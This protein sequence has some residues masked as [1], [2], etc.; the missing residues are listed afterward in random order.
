MRGLK[1]PGCFLLLASLFLICVLPG[2]AQSAQLRRDAS[3]RLILPQPQRPA[4]DQQAI[5]VGP[6]YRGAQSM[7]GDEAWVAQEMYK[8]RQDMM[9]DAVNRVRSGGRDDSRWL[10]R[11]VGPFVVFLVITGFVLWFIRAIL[12]N[13]RW[14]KMARIQTDAHTKVLDRLGSSQELLGYVESEAGKRFL[15]ATPFQIDRGPSPVFPFSRILWSAQAGVVITLVGVGFLALTTQLTEDT[16][17]LLVFGYLALALG[18]GFLLSAGL[19]YILSKRLGLLDSAK[20]GPGE[21]L[22]QRPQ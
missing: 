18:I 17:A 6:E 16:R 9:R 21:A 3:G 12:E 10:L 1:L 2:W 13:R 7:E 14:D 19:S 8:L 22:A 11:E 20:A 15:E 5:A 4:A